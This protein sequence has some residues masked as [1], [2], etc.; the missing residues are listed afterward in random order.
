MASH[1]YAL[2][3]QCIRVLDHTDNSSRSLFALCAFTRVLLARETSRGVDARNERPHILYVQ[4]KCIGHR[5][6]NPLQV[7]RK[8]KKGIK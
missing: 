1:V 3:L 6:E 7:K 2:Q 5:L 4:Q 8:Q